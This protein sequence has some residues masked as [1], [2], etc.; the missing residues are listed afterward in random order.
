M[1]K[2]L[3]NWPEVL[4]YHAVLQ[5]VLKVCE[6]HG[7]GLTLAY[8]TVKFYSVEVLGECTKIAPTKI[9]H[10]MLQLQYYIMVL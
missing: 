5:A 6:L 4:D 2:R 8:E 1:V 7:H 10:Y 3:I 9:S